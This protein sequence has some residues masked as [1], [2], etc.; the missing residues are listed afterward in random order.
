MKQHNMIR[1]FFAAATACVLALSLCAC[2]GSAGG[3]SARSLLGP[4]R[5]VRPPESIRQPRPAPI[6]PSGTL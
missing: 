1:K 6:S 3:G 2:S 5:S 4:R